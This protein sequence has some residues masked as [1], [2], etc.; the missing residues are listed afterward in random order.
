MEVVKKYFT[1]IHKCKV[2]VLR[3][4]KEH[5][6]RKEIERLILG[7]GVIYVGGGNTLLMMKLWRKEGVDKLLKK[8]WRKG[9]VL[10][11]LSAGA[12]CWFKYGNSDSLKVK[13]KRYQQIRVACLGFI[14]LMACPHY[15][16]E[17]NRRPS[18]FKMLKNRDGTAIA[19]DDRTA[20]EIVD[21]EYRIL[22]DIP[23]ANAYR[24]YRKG[25]KIV[26]EK[27]PAYG[28]W[29]KLITLMIS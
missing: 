19:L 14:P 6:E 18:L 20:F 8:A 22:R 2:E 5:P 12:L 15:D 16:L 3:L 10:S 23:R 13:G 24:V 26:E 9:I 17:K 29:R 1:N 21:N 11:G 7:A 27:I 28:Q 4:I 25:N